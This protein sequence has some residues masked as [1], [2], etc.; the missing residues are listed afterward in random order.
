MTDITAASP[1]WYR[2]LNPTQ[3]KTMIA[4]NLGWVF[5]GYETY[6]LIISV[7]VALCQLRDPASYAQIP[8][9]A[10]TVIA[11]PLLGWAIGGMVGGV[12]AD[13]IG[14]KRVMILGILA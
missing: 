11:L 2:S 8:V 3:W 7:G 9:Y 4:A 10:G 1:P 12:V 5:D 13:Y 6:A 14:R